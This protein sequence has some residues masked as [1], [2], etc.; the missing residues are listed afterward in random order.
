RYDATVDHESTLIMRVLMHHDGRP[1]VAAPRPPDPVPIVLVGPPRPLRHHLGC[2]PRA[3]PPLRRARV[4][5]SDGGDDCAS[6]TRERGQ[7]RPFGAQAPA[8]VA[9]YD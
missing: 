8:L 5:P 9:R 4:R 3:A 6:S 7:A 1:R 2:Q